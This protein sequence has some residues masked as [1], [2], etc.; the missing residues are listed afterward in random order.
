MRDVS[1][2]NFTVKGILFRVFPAF[3]RWSGGSITALLP[4]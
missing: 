2:G 4:A 1:S 3:V